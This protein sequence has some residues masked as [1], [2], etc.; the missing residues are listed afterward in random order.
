MDR[1]KLEKILPVLR[2]PRSGTKLSIQGDVLM[3]ETGER[4]PIVNGKPVLVRVIRPI[5][6]TPPPSTLVSQ[7]IGS[8]TPSPEARKVAGFKLHLGSGNV[9]CTDDDVISVDILPNT[10]VDIVAEAEHLPFA[11][12][13]LSWVESGAV[14]EHLYDP[15]AS[16]AEVRRVLV[17][18]G[19][20]YIDTAFMQGYHG[21]PS[22]YF[23]MTPQAV[24]TFIVSDF[25]LQKSFVPVG[26]GAA[27]SLENMLRKFI[28]VLP[29]A[30]RQK[31]EQMPAAELVSYL[32][33]PVAQSA[34]HSAMPEHIR[35]SLGASTCVIARKPAGYAEHQDTAELTDLR[36]D[37]Y[38]AR[39]GAMQRYYEVEF[40]RG[41][42]RERTAA[43]QGM[44]APGS[45]DELLAQCAPDSTLDPQSWRRAIE[46]LTA[47]ETEL[48]T[49]RDSWIR[50]FLSSP[51]T[52]IES[53]A[54]NNIA[55]IQ[56]AYQRELHSAIESHRSLESTMATRIVQLTRERD[57]I[58]SSTT[59]RF[60]EPIRR[61]LARLKRSTRAPSADD[62]VRHPAAAGE[63]G[64][65][66]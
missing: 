53:P 66:N 57:A 43:E 42:A 28:E 59:W 36:R 17:P 62:A 13:S 52:V 55:Q 8:Y 44:E 3:S 2:C 34:I 65:R 1:N 4:Y 16:A 50:I 48:T 63:H 51:E 27:V 29:A 12:E 21:Y 38:A 19:G 31:I 22:H 18:G 56:A 23:N 41:R 32:S 14:F 35:R 60:T 37:Y 6:I 15:L 9:P 64:L 54:A 49:V 47:V 7:N 58:L 61:V 24:E 30:E 46:A 20:F 5:H 25:E 45:L 10:N 11:T 26:A 40:Y 39:V 33:H